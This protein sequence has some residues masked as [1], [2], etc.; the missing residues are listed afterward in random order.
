MP[1]VLKRK[2]R[3]CL[4]CGVVFVPEHGN[5]YT[6]SAEC[7]RE[8]KLTRERLKMRDVRK[9]NPA[10]FAENRDADAILERRRERYRRGQAAR[11][12]KLKALKCP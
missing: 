11:R 5:A 3:A 7:K 6:C 10:K 1:R 8:R 12:S 4:C 9:S 2:P